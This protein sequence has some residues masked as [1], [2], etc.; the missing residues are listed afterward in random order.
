[1]K[2][3]LLYVCGFSNKNNRHRLKIRYVF[4]VFKSLES[5]QDVH[6]AMY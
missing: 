3:N 5:T 6:F 1:M 2:L 4:A